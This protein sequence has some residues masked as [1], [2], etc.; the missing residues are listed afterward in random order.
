MNIP[1]L[2]ILML[3]E[4]KIIQ[5]FPF[6]RLYG[7]YLPPLELHLHGLSRPVRSVNRELQNEKFLPTVGFEPGIFRLWSQLA[8][9]CTTRSSAY[10]NADRV[11][12]ECA[13]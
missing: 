3:A 9:R 11:L 13:I 1:F 10:W 7:L 4:I 12:P 6:V 5:Y 2:L 8:K